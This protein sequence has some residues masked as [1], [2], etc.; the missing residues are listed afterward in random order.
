MGLLTRDDFCVGSLVK[1][2]GLYMLER[3]VDLGLYMLERQADPGQYR[4]E[5]QDS[6]G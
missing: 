6:S 5:G 2:F 3:Q 4:L 1:L